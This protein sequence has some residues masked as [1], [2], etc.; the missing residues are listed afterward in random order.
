MPYLD[1]SKEEKQIGL[2]L[3]FTDTPGIKGR[4]KKFPEDFVVTERSIDVEP[5]SVEDQQLRP[6][7]LP[8]YTYAKVRSINW[9]TNRLVVRLARELG[10]N[11][12]KILFAGSKDKRAI[13]TQLMAF[14][15]PL[16]DVKKIELDNVELFDLFISPRVLKIG[17]LLGNDFTLRVRDI[18]ISETEATERI[19]NTSQQLEQI[20]G[21]PNFF[22][23]QRFG[24]IRPITHEIGKLLVE[25]RFEEAVWKYLANPIKGEPAND[26]EVRKEFERCWDFEW[27]L[28]NFPS[29]L[30]F[31]RIMIRYIVNH[32]DDY[33]GALNQIP[34][35]LNTMFI[36]AYQS[37]LFN[38]ILSARIRK[39]LPLNKPLIGDIVLP[40]DNN[41][42]PVHKTW[43]PVIE[44]NQDKLTGLCLKGKAYVS[45]VL[46]GSETGFAE[47]EF[48]EIERKIIKNEKVDANDFIIPESPNLSSKGSR[49]ELM[50]PFKNFKYDIDD[51]MI[52]FQFSL[53]KGVYAT[54]L[55]REYMKSKIKSY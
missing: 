42:L 43:I 26:Y 38:R 28:K 9:E 15:A 19:S 40:V 30:I 34:R 29:Y 45:G 54:T 32:P 4:L 2:E 39:G 35:N 46:F 16:D 49:R 48:G 20:N 36:N 52:T 6:H 18:E 47:G 11:F 25:K 21:F 1:S 14:E 33:L 53:F 13:T 5:I 24:V 51:G 8:I 12:N 22:G 50:A 10:I 7:T 41:R 3:F 27:A 17:D 44:Q 37:F 31:E 23:A 55:M